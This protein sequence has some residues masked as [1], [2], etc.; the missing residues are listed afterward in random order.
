MVIPEIEADLVVIARDEAL[1][2]GC[3]TSFHS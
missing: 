2:T 3:A 1:P